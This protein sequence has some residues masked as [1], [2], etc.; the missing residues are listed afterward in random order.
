MVVVVNSNMM[1]Q[2][3]AGTSKAIKLIG[4]IAISVTLINDLTNLEKIR[5][6]IN[7]L[8]ITPLNPKA[9]EE[10]QTMKRIKKDCVKQ[11]I[12][13]AEENK[14]ILIEDIQKKS[15]IEKEELD[16][17]IKRLLEEGDIYEHRPGKVRWLG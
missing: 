2:T 9:F 7:S 1:N 6:Y 10:D 5:D 4:E 11:I 16:R 13:E 3:A 8:L 17:I 14:G 12:K 15:K